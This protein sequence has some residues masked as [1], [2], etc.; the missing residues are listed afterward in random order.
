MIPLPPSNMR[1]IV[2]I[3]N[4]SI[5]PER[6]VNRSF[7]YCGGCCCSD[8]SSSPWSSGNRPYQTTP[9]KR[10]CQR[11]EGNTFDMVHGKLDR[12]KISIPSRK[13]KPKPKTKTTNYHRVNTATVFVELVIIVPH[14][15]STPW[16][17][18]VVSPATPPPPTSSHR[19]SSLSRLSNKQNKSDIS[20]SSSRRKGGV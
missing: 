2:Y 15:P 16:R 5:C 7:T 3:S 6:S 19:S 14:T 18:P 13:P 8:V 10:G 17:P 12:S 11:T 9:K 1:Y 20:S 4:L